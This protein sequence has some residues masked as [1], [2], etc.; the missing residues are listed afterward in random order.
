MERFRW[1]RRGRQLSLLPT[2]LFW[3]LVNM[4]LR[5]R[6]RASIVGVGCVGSANGP[7][8]GRGAPTVAFH[9]LTPYAHRAGV[10]QSEGCKEWSGGARDLRSRAPSAPLARAVP[11]TAP[12]TDPLAC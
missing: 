3:S 11:R 5:L 9:L 1:S 12:R 10:R 7:D 8:G 2:H 4:R 6:G